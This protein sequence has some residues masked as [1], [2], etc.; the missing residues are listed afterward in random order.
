MAVLSLVMPFKGQGDIDFALSLATRIALRELKANPHIPRLYDTKAKIKWKRDVCRAPNVPGACERF[1]SPLQV[2]A[3]GGIVDCDDAGPWRA[4]ELI[5]AGDE[6]ARAKSRP[7]NIG[8]HV[9]VERG[10]GSTEDPS[11]RLGMGKKRRP[12]RRGLRRP[13]RGRKRAA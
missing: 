8:Y 13:P 7:S 9:I 4:A 2:L 10:D 5:L 1:L 11:R 3:E 12:K 6:G